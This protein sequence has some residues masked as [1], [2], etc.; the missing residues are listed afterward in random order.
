MFRIVKKFMRHDIVMS[1]ANYSMANLVLELFKLHYN[2][3]L[4]LT[5]FENFNSDK[6]IEINMNYMLCTVALIAI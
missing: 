6:I 3:D 5:I 2:V 4:P 1:H